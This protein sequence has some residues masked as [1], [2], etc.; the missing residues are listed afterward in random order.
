MQYILRYVPE[1][2]SDKAYRNV[3]VVVDLPDVRVRDRRGYYASAVT[4][5]SAAH[6]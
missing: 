3:K 4:R 5:A 2:P 1:N 6:P